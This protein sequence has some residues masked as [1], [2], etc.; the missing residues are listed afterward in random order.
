M[1]RIVPEVMVR[2]LTTT[3]A[4]RRS[5]VL[6]VVEMT[7]SSSS[8]GATPPTQLALVFQGCVPETSVRHVTVAAKAGDEKLS[9]TSATRRRKRRAWRCP[10]DRL[11]VWRVRPPFCV[12]GR[13][14]A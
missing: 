11:R 7:T 14:S 13:W 1:R 2:L 8:V 4:L 12:A 9:A 5:T 10:A 3:W 6:V